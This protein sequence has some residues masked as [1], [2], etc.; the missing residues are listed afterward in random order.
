MA[1]MFSP[2]KRSQIM[3]SIR[4]K[5][6]VA[7]VLAFRF[8]RGQGIY[9][10]KHY[11]RVPGTP[12]IAL[13]R[14]KRAVFIDSDFWHGKTYQRLIDTR[15]AD[16]YWVKKIA[17]NIE[18]DGETRSSLIIGGWKILVVWESDIKRKRTRDATLN[19]IAGFLKE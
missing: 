15:P 7:E 5:N 2:E 12:D 1:D 10:Q 6:T 14:K 13:P 11:K 4:S 17:R 16:D 19:E 3:S 18:R 9:F 8:L